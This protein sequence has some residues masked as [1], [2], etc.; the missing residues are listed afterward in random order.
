MIIIKNKKVVKIIKLK[1]H[2]GP[3]FTPL[4]KT[5]NESLEFSAEL[6]IKDLF[7]YYYDKYGDKFRE[8]IWDKKIKDKYHNQLVIILNGRTYRDDNFLNTI[9]K[10]DD[11]VS[12][13][14]VYFGG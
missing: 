13:L 8:L 4:T 11:D 3:A 5:A 12:L 2:Y 14:Y 10:D 9:L 6:T 1:L 7:E